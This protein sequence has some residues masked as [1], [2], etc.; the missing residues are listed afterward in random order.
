MGQNIFIRNFFK[1]QKIQCSGQEKKLGL[2]QIVELRMPCVICIVFCSD[3]GINIQFLNN[4]L[5][6]FSFSVHQ[7][8]NEI[9]LNIYHYIIYYYTTKTIK[10]SLWGQKAGSVARLLTSLAEDPNLVLSNI[11]QLTA[12]CYS[13]SNGIQNRGF[14]WYLHSHTHTYVLCIHIIKIIKISLKEKSWFQNV[15][16]INLKI[17][18]QP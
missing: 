1:I 3:Q 14:I 9:Y 7:I 10:K 8:Q 6:M 17:T 11:G 5:E 18:V 16:Q 13:S 2:Y 15:A 4:T 12:A